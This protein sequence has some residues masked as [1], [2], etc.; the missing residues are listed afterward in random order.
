[1]G[2]EILP[3][4]LSV[5]EAELLDLRRRLRQ[6]GLFAD[7]VRAFFRLVRL[8]AQSRPSLR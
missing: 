3:F 2:Q 4:R 6:P 8:A 7:E 5:P 1:M